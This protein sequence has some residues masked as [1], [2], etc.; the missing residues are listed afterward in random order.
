MSVAL[1]LQESIDRWHLLNSIF[2]QS[3]S[4]GTLPLGA[5]RSYAREYGAFI[6][7]VPNGW[8]SHDDHVIAAEE[9]AHVELW[10]RFARALG[11]EIGVPHVPA[12]RDLVK[13]AERLF[14]ERACA[15]GALYGFEAQQPAAAKSKLEGLR[16]HY[17]LPESAQA[18]FIVHADDD[19]EPNLLLERIRQLPRGERDRAAS[20]CGEMCQALRAALDG[21]A[22]PHF[23][24]L[25]VSS[26]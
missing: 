6:S 4:A 3:W 10:R 7:L 16:A 26:N 13:A 14:S 11:T 8:A 21:L 5:L 23:E 25:A 19:S 20:A 17:D 2:Y 1:R 12:V 22:A 24:Y 15:L 9:R 18:Y